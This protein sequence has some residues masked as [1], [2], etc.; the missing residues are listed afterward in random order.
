MMPLGFIHNLW[1]GTADSPATIIDSLESTAQ[2][3]ERN[4]GW[5]PIL[6]YAVAS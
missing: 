1:A 3:C 5:K 4:T 6:L 2:R